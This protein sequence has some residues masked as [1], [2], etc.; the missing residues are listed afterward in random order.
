M[1]VVLPL[2]VAV[3]WF[4]RR[5]YDTVGD[6]LELHEDQVFEA[7][8]KKNRV[9]IPVMNLSR[10]V[11][12]VGAVR[13]L[14]LRRRQGRAHHRR[15]RGGRGAAR[16]SGRRRLPGVPL[17][18]VETPYRSLVVPFLHYLDVMAP[19]EEDTI[20]IVVLPEYVPRHFWDRIL[21]NQTAD[22]LKSA[23]VGRPDTVVA[24]V[25]YGS[26][27]RHAGIELPRLWQAR[28]S[29]RSRDRERRH[30]DEAEEPGREATTQGRSTRHPAPPGDRSPL[31]RFR[32][33][34]IL[35]HAKPVR[36]SDPPV[37]SA[38]ASLDEGT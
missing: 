7:P 22:Q 9:L 19:T 13:A 24:D 32:R 26:E 16:S 23:L 34:R 2:Q 33:A 37:Q 28:R 14:A 5:E 25:P 1:L 6:D 38:T 21:Y 4:I 20:T 3:M 12:P 27:H 18:I 30:T 31:S 15:P 11:G 36:A 10:A 8:A 17:V 29:R 35:S